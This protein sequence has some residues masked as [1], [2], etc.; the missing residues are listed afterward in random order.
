MPAQESSQVRRHQRA[1]S[2][3]GIESPE[4]PSAALRSWARWSSTR[5]SVTWS[6][7]SSTVGGIVTPS[8]LA[9]L[10]L[11]SRKSLV[12]SSTGRSPGKFGRQAREPFE[13]VLG[14]S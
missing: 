14:E 13:L 9:V 5:Y 6:A 7:R 3:D 12:G 10:R 1:R 4:K 2:Y 8:A 11:I